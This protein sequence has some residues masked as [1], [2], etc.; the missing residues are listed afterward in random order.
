MSEAVTTM[1]WIGLILEASGIVLLITSEWPKPSGPPAECS[2]PGHEG[3]SRVDG[4]RLLMREG[5]S[6][7][8]LSKWR[9]WV[10]LALALA[11]VGLLI[12]V[13]IAIT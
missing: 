6:F 9:P 10:G 8:Q 3:D 7:P 5:K 13:A 4:S 1:L 11:G 2:V 12:P